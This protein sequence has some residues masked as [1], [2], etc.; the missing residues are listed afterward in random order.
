MHGLA[1]IATVFWTA[2]GLAAEKTTELHLVRIK[3]L[4]V[5]RLRLEKQVIERHLIDRKGLCLAPRF[6]R[7]PLK[8]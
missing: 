1:A 3:M 7:G 2:A 8:P 6:C 4:A 5:Q